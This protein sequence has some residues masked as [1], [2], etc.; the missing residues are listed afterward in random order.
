MIEAVRS[1]IIT[2]WDWQALALGF[3]FVILIGVA[4]LFLASRALRTRM[5]RT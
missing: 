1:L 5:T 4:S 3:G 2:G